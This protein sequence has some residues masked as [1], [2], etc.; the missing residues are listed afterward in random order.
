MDVLIMPKFHYLISK[1]VHLKFL[2]FFYQVMDSSKRRIDVRIQPN[3]EEHTSKKIDQLGEDPNEC[4][5]I[6]ENHKIFKET[7]ENWRTR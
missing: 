5:G 1:L 4:Q 6:R 3:K 7:K 2:I